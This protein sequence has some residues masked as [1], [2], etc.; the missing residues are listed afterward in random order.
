VSR[1]LAMAKS[2]VQTKVEAWL[3]DQ[4]YPLEM[5]T[6]RAFQSRGW[7][8][9]Q[10]RRYKDPVLE[11]EREIDL[12]AFNDDPAPSSKIHGHFVIECKWS[13]QKPWVLFAATVQSLTSMGHFRST[14]MTTTA[15]AAVKNL[16]LKDIS[17]FPLFSC[18]AEHYAIVQAF[19]REL[20]IDAAY[21]AVHAAVSAA[22]FF[23]ADMSK[24]SKHSIFYLP[25]VVLDGELFQCSLG[26]GGEASVRPVDIGCLIHRTADHNKLVH[27]VRES[28][29]SKFIDRAE[30]TFRCLRI[31][32]K[33]G[34]VE[35][36]PKPKELSG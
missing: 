11:K 28:A 15:T 35:V 10:S 20:A 18:I 6:A 22:D 19:S 25:T 33:N 21:S 26:E 3:K 31:A 29:L 12:L 36:K 34:T 5:R 9:H 32:A 30:E 24:S 2:E 27:I 8:L 1:K 13:P 23:A 16:V 14:P 7:F 4:G 17:G